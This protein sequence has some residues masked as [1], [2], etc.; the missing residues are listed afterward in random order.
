MFLDIELELLGLLAEGLGKKTDY[1]D[2]WFRN[3]CSSR[4]RVIH[5]VSRSDKNALDCS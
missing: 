4:F 1:F 3:E 2:P 5:N